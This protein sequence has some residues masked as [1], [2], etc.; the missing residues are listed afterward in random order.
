VVLPWAKVELIEASSRIGQEAATRPALERLAAGTSA[1]GT[2][3][4]GERAATLDLEA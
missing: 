1:S 2:D 4:A 3:W